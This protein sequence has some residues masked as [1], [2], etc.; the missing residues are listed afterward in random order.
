MEYSE[1]KTIS[2]FAV[3]DNRGQPED[4]SYKGK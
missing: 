1:R 4:P 3:I 2:M